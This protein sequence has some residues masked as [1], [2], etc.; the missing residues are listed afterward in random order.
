MAVIEHIMG[1]ETESCAIVGAPGTGK[2]RL[3]RDIYK[4]FVQC[5]VPC[6]LLAPT[7]TARIVLNPDGA[8]V[9]VVLL[10][11]HR[12]SAR[13]ARRSPTRWS[14]SCTPT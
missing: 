2:S 8:H 13:Q 5:K 12:V 6:V 10:H 14:R 11:G 1:Q 7:H 9:P 3:F 4:T